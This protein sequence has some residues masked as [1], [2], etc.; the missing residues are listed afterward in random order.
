MTIITFW[1]NEF[2]DAW[3]AFVSHAQML[4]GIMVALLRCALYCIAIDPFHQ[5]VFVIDLLINLRFQCFE[6]FAMLVVS[7]VDVR[8]G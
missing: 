1:F 7:V 5:T 2:S 8:G 4:I 6:I 3:T